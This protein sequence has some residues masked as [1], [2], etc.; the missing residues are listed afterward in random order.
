MTRTTAITL[1]A[2][3]TQRD[4]IDRAANALGMSRSEF[5]LDSACDRAHN[6]LLDRTFFELEEGRFAEFTVLL[7]AP[8]A[9]DAGLERL[10][11]AQAPWEGHS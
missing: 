4:L 5:V 7:D 1:R 10:L 2:Q 9:A 8:P 11:A 6:V 3:P